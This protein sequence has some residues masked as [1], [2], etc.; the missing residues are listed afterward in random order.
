MGQR[1]NDL[2][3]Q[4]VA[5]EGNNCGTRSAAGRHNE[6]HNDFPATKPLSCQFADG[7]APSRPEPE[8]RAPGGDRQSEDE[9]HA[10]KQPARAQHGDDSA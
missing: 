2:C 7:R 1:D 10:R 6:S 3:D 8:N 5:D 9:G 4:A